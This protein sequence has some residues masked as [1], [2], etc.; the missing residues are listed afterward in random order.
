MRGELIQWDSYIACDF[1]FDYEGR[2]LFDFPYAIKASC[3]V[4]LIKSIL[5]VEIEPRGRLPPSLAPP[6]LS[7]PPENHFLTA[8]SISRFPRVDLIA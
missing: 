4:A 3:T 6:K 7:L 8:D 2:F 1:D 5:N